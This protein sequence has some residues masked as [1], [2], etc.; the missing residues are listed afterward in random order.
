MSSDSN[1]GWISRGSEHYGVGITDAPPLKAQRRG[2]ALAFNRGLTLI[3]PAWP[4]IDLLTV[5]ESRQMIA[6]VEKIRTALLTTG[7][8]YLLSISACSSS[9]PGQFY[10]GREAVRGTRWGLCP[11]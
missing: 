9:L 2:R 3:I 6:V 1:K 11:I 7:D 8:I 10:K 5:G 4:V